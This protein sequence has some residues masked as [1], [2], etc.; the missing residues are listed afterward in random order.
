MIKL[1][2]SES[3][4]TCFSGAFLLT[5]SLATFSLTFDKALLILVVTKTMVY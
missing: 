5:V 1:E 2:F 3:F 4:L